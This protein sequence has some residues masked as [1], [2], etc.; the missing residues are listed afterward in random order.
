MTSEQT[1]TVTYH[2][3]RGFYSESV[4]KD[5][6][7]AE[8]KATWRLGFYTIKGTICRATITHNQQIINEFEF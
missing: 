8:R 7:E 5:L 4:F 2:T 1:Y 3:D 6:A